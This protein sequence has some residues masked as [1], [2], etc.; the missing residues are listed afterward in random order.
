MAQAPGF[1]R[2]R[3][4][5]LDVALT[6]AVA[7]VQRLLLAVVN[8][9]ARAAWR[10]VDPLAV[11]LIVGQ[12]L[13]LVVRRRVPVAV[14]AVVLML[15][16]A[17]YVAGYPPSGL[18]LALAIALY[19]VAALRPRAASL[20]CCLGILAVCSLLWLLR[21]GPYWSR[22]SLPLVIY[23]LVFFSAAWAWGRYH[24]TRQEMR[25]V[26]TAELVARA[27]QA[28]R[29]RSTATR[30]ILAEERSRI[31]RELHDSVA[32]HMS[33]MVVQAGAARRIL[34]VDPEGARRAL[35]S[36]EDAG[37]RGLSTMPSLV[38][39]LRGDEGAAALSP[40]PGLDRLDDMVELVR[41]AGLP[42]V[43][44][45]E[46]NPAPL[47]TAVEL[48]VYRIVQE[49]LTN[50]LRHAGPATAH[51]CL[52]YRRDGLEVTVTDDGFGP[53]DDAGPVA[54][55]G[56][57]GMRERVHLLGGDFC[58]GRGEGGGFVVRARF[59]LEAEG[60]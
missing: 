35:A 36:I 4:R 22:A 60:R 47:P 43:V 19:T 23:L 40:Q 11:A 33:V 17:Y 37:R 45:R 24:R 13:P 26:Q 29:D 51:V 20:L 53:K 18:D 7:G 58:A 56:L 30:Q 12:A 49:A 46:G 31:A 6:A 28:E 8:D 10:P 42:V 54:G 44:E 52:A 5:L 2:V 21:V 25:D 38:R 39:A 41:A 34:D 1:R 50:T 32:H 57:L 55:H 9:A 48:S 3:G 27:E 59:P 16:S 14:F 15:N